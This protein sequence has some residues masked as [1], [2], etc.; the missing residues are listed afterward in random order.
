MLDVLLF[1]ECTFDASVVGVS[2]EPCWAELADCLMVLDHAGGAVPAGDA[3]AGV[4]TLE[5]LA[6]HVGRAAG[7]LQ[8]DADFRGAG[9]V[10]DAE[11]D[12]IGHGAL[13]SSWAGGGGARG[14]AGPGH[15][16]LG[17]RALLVGFAPYA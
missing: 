3:V 16:G 4:H 10:A 17:H 11:R 5:L 9:L 13:L 12:V 6:G 14:L 8:A 7:V 15:A 1:C 2:L